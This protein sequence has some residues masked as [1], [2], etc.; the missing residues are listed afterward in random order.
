MMSIKKMIRYL[1]ILKMRYNRFLIY[2]AVLSFIQIVSL[3]IKLEGWVG[4]LGWGFVL[5]PLYTFNL[6]WVFL[7]LENMYYRWKPNLEKKNIFMWSHI[8]LSFL[9]LIPLWIFEVLL[10]IRLDNGD[11]PSFSIVFAPLYLTFIMIFLFTVT[12]LLYK[13]KYQK[14]DSSI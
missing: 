5:I 8:L 2:G 9:V 11:S 4:S 6:T 3:V 1:V 14:A 13:A 12:Y 10:N 7:L